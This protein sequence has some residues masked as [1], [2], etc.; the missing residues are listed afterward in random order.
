MEKT[1]SFGMPK[2]L[3]NFFT[4]QFLLLFVVSFL[5]NFYGN[6][7]V[8]LL[9]YDEVHGLTLEQCNALQDNPVLEMTKDQEYI[10]EYLRGSSWRSLFAQKSS[11]ILF[12]VISPLISL[13]YAFFVF[14]KKSSSG[15][16]KNS[17]P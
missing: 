7:Q 3:D 2:Q 11:Q 12:S 5:F 10:C 4:L 14:R 16:I 1:G 15:F 6:A 8:T 13:Y 9:Y 17:E